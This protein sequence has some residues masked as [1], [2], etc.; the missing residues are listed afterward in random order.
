MARGNSAPAPLQASAATYAKRKK[1]WYGAI[2]STF[3][4][5]ER[6]FSVSLA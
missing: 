6:F 3:L 5:A 1:T 4:L 2:F